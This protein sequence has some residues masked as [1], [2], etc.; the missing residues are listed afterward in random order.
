MIGAEC[1]FL[2]GV[3][4]S[5]AI[6]LFDLPEVAF[7]GKSNVGKSSLIN[8]ILG[9]KLLAR[10]SKTPGRTKQLN[11]FSLCHSLNF[12]VS[13]RIQESLLFTTADHIDGVT[14][15]GN[16]DMELFHSAGLT[17]NIGK[18]KDTNQ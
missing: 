17:F 14:A 9:R 3:T 18:Q 7:W 5:N 15:G 1:T 2:A 10:V 8:A 6:P 12:V 4:D 11:F 16:N 13:I